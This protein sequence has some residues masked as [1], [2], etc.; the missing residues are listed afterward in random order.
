MPGGD[1]KPSLIGCWK[2]PI[3]AANACVC[4]PCMIGRQC[5]AL[6]GEKDTMNCC[7]C[8]LSL[9]GTYGLCVCC[10]RRKV[11]EKYSQWDE[12]CCVSLCV[13]WFCPCCSLVQTH[14]FL[15]RNGMNPGLVIGMPSLDKMDDDQ[16]AKFHE[17]RQKR[18][19]QRRERNAK[20][21]AD[22]NDEKWTS[23]ES[24]TSE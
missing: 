1:R 19:E 21:R 2:K 14:K 17:E 6:D 13:A 12:N 16:K 22:R 4:W 15:R 18:R 7:M 24:D 23:S 5:A 8:L 10:I 20:R 9:F 3:L 11:N